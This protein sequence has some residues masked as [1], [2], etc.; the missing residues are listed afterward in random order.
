LLRCR[1]VQRLDLF[2]QLRALIH[3]VLDALGV[4][5][6]LDVLTGCN[7]VVEADALDIAAVARIALV[8]NNDVIERAFLGTAAG[9]ANLDHD[10]SLILLKFPARTP[11]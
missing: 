9:K 8:G 2:S 3:P 6:E 5:L 4:E 10:I 7:R 11:A 1:L